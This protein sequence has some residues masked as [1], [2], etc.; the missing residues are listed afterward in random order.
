MV[1]TYTSPYN[2]K[3]FRYIITVLVIKVFLN[4]PQTKTMSQ[5][6]I[7]RKYVNRATYQR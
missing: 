6:M 4:T 2:L 3:C 1:T 5:W 7:M